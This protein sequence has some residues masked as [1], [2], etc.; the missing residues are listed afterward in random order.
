MKENF[1]IIQNMFGEEPIKGNEADPFRSNVFDPNNFYSW[2][3]HDRKEVTSLITRVTF[4]NGKKRKI[5]LKD[6]KSWGK[7]FKYTAI[8]EYGKNTRFYTFAFAIGN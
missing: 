5:I 4:S 1:D 8:T 3:I 2:K 6:Q 7:H